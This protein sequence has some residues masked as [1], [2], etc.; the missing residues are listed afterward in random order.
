MIVESADPDKRNG[1]EDPKADEPVEGSHARQVTALLCD[2]REVTW[3]LGEYVFHIA[4]GERGENEG[5]Y[6]CSNAHRKLKV[7]MLLTDRPVLPCCRYQLSIQTEAYI[8]DSSLMTARQA[9]DGIAQSTC[10]L[11]CPHE[12]F[13]CSF[14]RRRCGDQRRRAGLF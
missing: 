10:P 13:V 5:Q 11:D 12:T 7:Y 8:Q 14:S 2:A 1:P 6:S 9:N 3:E 4:A